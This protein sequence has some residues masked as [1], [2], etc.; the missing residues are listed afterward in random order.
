MTKKI[1]KSLKKNERGYTA[2][3]EEFCRQ[4]FFPTPTE[5]V[6]ELGTQ[7]VPFNGTRAAMR[8]G[9]AKKSASVAANRLL[10][11]D[12]IQRLMAEIQA[13]ALKRFEITRDRIL[14]EYAAIAFSNILDFVEVDPETKEAWID[15]SKATREEAAALSAFDVTELPPMKTVQGGE[16]VCREVMRTKIKMHDKKQALDF[17][18]RMEGILSPDRLDV[19]VSQSIDETDR[20]DIAKRVAFMLRRAAEAEGNKKEKG[21]E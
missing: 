14:Q 10:G 19:S 3:E 1:S 4:Y 6:P 20:I 11:N 18:A 8:S 9:Y 2:R 13:P 7:D 15:I 12:K 21:D 16:E 17:L 5:Y